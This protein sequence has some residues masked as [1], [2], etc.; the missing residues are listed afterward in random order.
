MNGVATA[1]RERWVIARPG[2]AF[3]RLQFLG[4]DRHGNS[5]WFNDPGHGAWSYDREFTKRELHRLTDPKALALSSLALQNL[6]G[7][8]I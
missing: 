4:W 2:I 7:A 5:T 1:E 8:S 3:G 6:S